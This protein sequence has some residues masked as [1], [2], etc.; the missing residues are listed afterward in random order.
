MIN[1]NL[2]TC[3]WRLEGAKEETRIDLVRGSR[4]TAYA[5]R[6]GSSVLASDGLWELEPMPSHRDDE[7]LARCRFASFADAVAAYEKS[8]ACPGDTTT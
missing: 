3:S 8:I 1:V 7:F 6:C 2:D 4:G 5:V